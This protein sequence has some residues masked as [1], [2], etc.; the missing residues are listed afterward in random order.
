MRAP[1]VC[2]A[3]VAVV[4][5]AAAQRTGATAADPAPIAKA[6]APVL[7]VANPSSGGWLA[8]FDPLTLRMLPGR[9]AP[10]GG[11]YGS[12]AFSANRATLAIA[13][14]GDHRGGGIRFV[15]ARTMRVL[16]DLELSRSFSNCT[17]SLTWL[18]PRRLL[19]VVQSGAHVV[20]VDPVARRVLRRTSLPAAPWATA[21][22]RTRHELVLLLGNQGSFAPA[23]LAIVDAEGQM[24]IATVDRILAG[25]I[26]E[27][28]SSEY[29]SRAIQPG[30]TVDPE[31]RRAF[32]APHAGPVAEIDLRTLAVTYHELDHPSLLGRVLRWLTPAAEAKVL[33]GPI[34]NARWLG[35][36]MMAVSGTDYSVTR[37]ATGEPQMVESPAGVRL[38]D[39][40]TW[41]ARVLDHEASGVAVGAGLVVAQGGRWDIER[42]RGHGPGLRAF[43]LDGREH[44]RHRPGEL[45]WMDPAGLFG[46]IQ[47]RDRKTEVIDLVK[48]SVLATVRWD[49][50]NPTIEQPQLL[51][52]QVSDW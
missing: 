11:H 48:G 49:E 33:E 2:A 24:R 50:R 18:A 31:G 28:G 8:W 5:A 35:D 17:S 40:R 51:A 27:D 39:T 15:N 38:I 9:K 23:R 13:S 10:L 45:L 43:G 30:L 42:E 16:G 19:A 25:S 14:C 6:P 26:V 32:L 46:Y 34:R 7:G 4:A 44:W 37:S 3:L 52:A 22:V 20:V 41:T 36:G 12:W 1:L 21:G 47:F 29:H